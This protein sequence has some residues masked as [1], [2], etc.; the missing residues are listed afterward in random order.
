MKRPFKETWSNSNVASV[1]L[2]NAQF[3]ISFAKGKDVIGSLVRWGWLCE[4]LQ[5]RGGQPSQGP[6]KGDWNKRDWLRLLRCC[7]GLFYMV[8]T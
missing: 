4:Q 5:K 1:W 7:S 6:K 3:Y 8:L 2:A